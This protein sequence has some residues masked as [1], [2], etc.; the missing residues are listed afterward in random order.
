M[1]N[2]RAR[3]PYPSDVTDTQWEILAPLIPEPGAC[4]V[5]GFYRHPSP[6]SRNER[7]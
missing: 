3:K 2:Q 1:T 7:I 5:I 4:F 6:T